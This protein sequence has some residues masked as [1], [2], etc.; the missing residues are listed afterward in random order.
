MKR[1]RPA[2]V[3]ALSLFFAFGAVISAIT[4]AMLVL[5]GTGLVR[6]WTLFPSLQDSLAQ[7][8]KGAA[9]WWGFACVA[10]VVAA[11]GLWRC[12]YW[13]YLTAF[14]FLF[15]LVAANLF[16]ALLLHDWLRLLTSV[17]IGALLLW[18]LR[19]REHVFAHTEPVEPRPN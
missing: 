2:D 8:G 18:Y 17:A 5:T 15:L 6:N 1:N 11:R 10:C 4:G 12:S 14:I 9:S 16:D 13:G 7:T 19:T 3:T